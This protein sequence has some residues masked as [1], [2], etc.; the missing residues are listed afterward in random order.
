M[1]IAMT[2]IYYFH[3][4]DILGIEIISVPLLY[5]A[6]VEFGKS[7]F[8]SHSMEIIFIYTIPILFPCHFQTIPQYFHSISILLPQYFHSISIVFPWYFHTIFILFSWY[9]H[10]ISIQWKIYSKMKVVHMVV[11][12]ENHKSILRKVTIH[13]MKN[14]IPYNV[15]TM[16]KYP[17]YLHNV[18][19]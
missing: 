18:D 7:Q 2:K 15:H 13:T 6:I 4:M 14:D 9:Y 12:M 19:F 3:V 1:I 10:T 16:E 8:L 17:Y 5:G 11:G